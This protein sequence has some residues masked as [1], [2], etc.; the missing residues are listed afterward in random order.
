MAF[1]NINF[2]KYTTSLKGLPSLFE[3]EVRALGTVA[4]FVGGS[5]L[6]TVLATFSSISESGTFTLVNQTAV[7]IAQHITGT[8]PG[9]IQIDLTE[10]LEDVKIRYRI[11][12][13]NG[14]ADW[15]ETN[16]EKTPAELFAFISSNT[17]ADDLPTVPKNNLNFAAYKVDFDGKRLE[18]DVTDTAEIEIYSPRLAAVVASIEFYIGEDITDDNEGISYVT[19]TNND[20]FDGGNGFG[21]FLTSAILD[22][23]NL[24]DSVVTSVLNKRLWAEARGYIGTDLGDAYEIRLKIKD[25]GSP[26]ESLTDTATIVKM[27]GITA[28]QI[29]TRSIPDP[30]PYDTCVQSGHWRI[31]VE[32]SYRQVIPV[33]S[34]RGFFDETTIETELNGGGWLAAG[35]IAGTDDGICIPGA[36]GVNDVGLRFE[37]KAPAAYPW[38]AAPP[39]TVLEQLIRRNANSIVGDAYVSLD[40]ASFPHTI[41]SNKEKKLTVRREVRSDNVSRAGDVIEF[42]TYIAP[43]TGDDPKTNNAYF[44]TYYNFDSS[45]LNQILSDVIFDL[46]NEGWYGVYLE[47]VVKVNNTRTV[48]SFQNNLFYFYSF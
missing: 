22:P 34:A 23:T 19:G 1:V 5:T 18:L 41:L 48:E 40:L 8:F 35:F 44:P 12:D 7:D 32:D 47:C 28:V 2:N 45:S 14:I 46:K 36:S 31:V 24:K 16:Y 9:D 3:V 4:G 30:A 38:V 6:D 15:V 17:A 13:G 21:D 42:N 11:T 37:L 10:L 43:N 25:G 33:A 27:Y 39:A 26:V 29:K 20:W